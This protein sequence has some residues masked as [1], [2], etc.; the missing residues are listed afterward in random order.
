[1]ISIRVSA[2]VR[3]AYF[4]ALLAQPISALDKY[5][6][7]EVTNAITSA[8]NTI[9]LAIS[10]KL[11]LLVQTIALVISAFVIAFKYS[12]ALTLVSG[13]SMLFVL[14]VFGAIVPPF[15]VRLR[16]VE[17]AEEQASGIA[18]EVFASIRTVLA[19]GAE[20]ELRERYAKTLVEVR[21]LGH[22]LSFLNGAQFAPAFFAIYCDYALTFWFGI[23]LYREGT[24]AN[25]NTVI[26]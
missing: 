15:I 14:L 6:A 3:L 23:K 13:S 18:S 1:M 17:K 7:G 20:H 12:W 8:T 24:I 4:N 21:R 16:R 9:Q 2:T 10:D 26:M 11:A 22:K 25:V 19:L 5:P